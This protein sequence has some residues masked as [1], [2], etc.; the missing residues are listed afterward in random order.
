[1]RKVLKLDDTTPPTGREPVIEVIGK[2]R[3]A[4]VWVGDNKNCLGT[5]DLAKLKKFLKDKE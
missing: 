1:M 2:G 3:L 5:I 4:Y